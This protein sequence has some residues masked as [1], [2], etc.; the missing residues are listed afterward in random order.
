MMS[1]GNGTSNGNGNGKVDEYVKSLPPYLRF[2]W[3]VLNKLGLA[4]LLVIGAAGAGVYWL[5][6]VSAPEVSARLQ[7][8]QQTTENGNRMIK[9]LDKIV[10]NE[11]AQIRWQQE[12][13]T[14]VEAQH[15]LRCEEAK[16]IVAHQQKADLCWEEQQKTN[17]NFFKRTDEI[18][19]EQIKVLAEL[20]I[21]LRDLKKL[22]GSVPAKN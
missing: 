16:A 2:M 12:W 11:D 18:H 8:L 14:Y 1:S 20:A 17:N 21:T 9:V 4:T 3:L 10:D 7:L 19:Q 15:R 22:N 13:R 5:T 6:Y